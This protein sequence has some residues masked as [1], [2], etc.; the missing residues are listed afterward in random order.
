MKWIFKLLLLSSILPHE[1]LSAQVKDRTV[2]GI[3]Y[4]KNNKGK[5]EVLPGASIGIPGT[6]FGTYSDANG[7]FELTLPDSNK[8]IIASFTGYTPDTIQLKDND[9]LQ[10]VFER[11]YM[12]DEVVV[13]KRQ[14]SSEVSLL[15]TNKVE[16][17]GHNELTKAACCNLSESFET[18]P[19]IDVSFTDAVTGYKQITMLGLA[20]PYTLITRENI[21]DVSGLAAITGLTY[22]PG[23][24]IESMQLSKG[25]GSVVNGYESVAG[26][27]NIEL[28]KPFKGDT[29]LFNLYQNTNGR[30]EANVNYRKKLTRRLSTNLFLHGQS[31]WMKTDENDDGFLD[32]PLGNQF[33]GISRWFY[34]APKDWE[35]QGGVKAIYV[36]NTGGQ[37]SYNK[38][39]EQVP[40]NPWGYTLDTKR[41]EEWAK[42]GK[43]YD[44]KPG[45]SFG[46]Q[47]SNVY[48]EQHA[49]YGSRVYDATQKSLYANFIF[50]TII[51]NT[52][53]VIKVGLSNIIDQY[54]ERLDAI[55]TDRTEVVPGVFTEYAYT[56]SEK[57]SL[58][59]GLRADHDN[60]YGGFITPR[61]H[62][63]YAP[64][65]ST[66]I[67]ASIGRAQRTANIFAENMGYMA[68]NREFVIA[69]AASDKAY[70]L[71]P[72]VAWNYGVNL[73]HKFTI[74]YRDGAFSVDYYYTDFQ[75]QV[76]ADIENPY[77][78]QFYN[79]SGRSYAHSFQAQLDYELIHN[80]DVRIAYRWYD[81]Q[82]TYNGVQ[83]EKPLIAANRAFVNIGYATKNHWKFDYTLQWAG[84]KRMPATY[85]TTEKSTPSYIQ[86]N[87]QVT[88]VFNEKFEVYMG[89]ENLT[90]Y[91]QPDPI[92]GANTP[93]GQG[94]DAGMIWGP[95]MGRNIYAG[96]RYKI[97]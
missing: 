69:N 48:H 38:G 22:T 72:E 50:Q 65:Q 95:V 11:S 16:H 19:S 64:N 23:S 71:D 18:T 30:S 12:L 45:T 9:K 81:V 80:L 4:Q 10:I 92:I 86:M 28:E 53:N 42:I 91:V 66:S 62:M 83:K 84:T 85:A 34:D 90:N 68:S 47:L 74:D 82:T 32:Q 70:G 15:S 14:K 49:N 58:V 3:V 5:R 61:L 87:A 8:Y 20:G 27:I 44:D 2:H 6:G 39:T 89:G 51:H 63:R 97:P 21:P 96:L 46:L 40:G 26:Q 43:V 75:N 37:W 67:R 79:L 78:V 13:S 60:I 94:F 24:W 93:Y 54:D 59:A 41:L 31:Q 56:Y 88:K 25:T 1:Y 55:R 17:I 7:S 57:F 33:S 73:T 35:I 52:N 36:A 76:V 77:L 29:W